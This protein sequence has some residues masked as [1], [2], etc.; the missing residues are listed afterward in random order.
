[1]DVDVSKGPRVE[2]SSNVFTENL[3]TQRHLESIYYV[4]DLKQTTDF[5][6]Y[7][8]SGIRI[9]VAARDVNLVPAYDDVIDTGS[10]NDFVLTNPGA[11]HAD[12]TRFKDVIRRHCRSVVSD[13][14]KVINIVRKADILYFYGKNKYIQRSI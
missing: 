1:M 7:R 12:V 13:W 10:D 4:T 9:N 2:V 6:W 8:T 5:A 14:L 11:S 3:H